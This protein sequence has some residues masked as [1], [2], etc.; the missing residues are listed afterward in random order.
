MSRRLH[1]ISYDISND[2]HRLKV[3]HLLEG[4]G[5]R[6]QYSVFEVWATGEELEKL[7]KRLAL[8][9]EEEGSGAMKRS[10]RIYALCAL[11]ESTRKVLGEGDPTGEPDLQIV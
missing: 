7:E 1:L 9:V 5:E 3:M 11:C 2:K 4:Y 10:V 6:V 8:H